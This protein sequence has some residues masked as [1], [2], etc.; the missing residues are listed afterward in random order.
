MLRCKISSSEDAILDF[1]LP[2]SFSTV[3]NVD[4]EKGSIRW[5]F[6]TTWP[7]SRVTSR[8]TFNTRDAGVCRCK[9]LGLRINDKIY[10]G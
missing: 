6:V 9:Y 2:V 10:I 3:G 4:P 7:T 8:G 1:P 5:N